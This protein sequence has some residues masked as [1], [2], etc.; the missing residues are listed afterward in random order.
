MLKS[1]KFGE[2][3]GLSWKGAG[4]DKL[5]GD[6]GETEF[7]VVQGDILGLLGDRSE[8]NMVGDKG[9]KDM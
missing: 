9:A 2:S 3:L 1:K 7:A 6:F 5:C 8:L 4:E